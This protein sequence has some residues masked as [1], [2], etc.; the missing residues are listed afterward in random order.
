MLFTVFILSVLVSLINP[1]GLAGFLYPLNVSKN[2]GYTIVENQTMFLLESI[3]FKDPN[4]IFVKLCWGIIV[5]SLI[6]VLIRRNFDI[7]NILL[8]LFGLV[9]SFLNVRSFP[10][11]IFLSL[12]P[13]LQNFGPI[14][15]NTF[16]KTLS[17]IFAVVLIFE[18]FGYF[19]TGLILGESAKGAMDFVLSNDLPTPI[20][21]NFDIGSYIIYRGF[22]KYKVFVD[23]RPEA[24]PTE[25]FQNTYIPMQ[26][27]YE[28]FKEEEQKWGFKTIIF[29]HTDQTPWGQT[30][31]QNI[32][33]DAAWKLV[34]ADN[35][36]I[37]LSRL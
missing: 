25:F 5:L 22:P 13:V 37:V 18:S 1:N 27:N 23:G 12:P 29:S 11:L 15:Q 31:L 32:V 3:N 35:F 20:F 7:K 4:F 24:Y 30:F 10:Y 17:L 14:R 36:M 26:S 8:T 16:T 33:K 6:Y 34:F 21:N 19:K 9:L 2:Y 28:K